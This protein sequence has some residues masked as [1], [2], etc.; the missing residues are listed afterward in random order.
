MGVP[1][2]FT[3]KSF[4]IFKLHCLSSW[5][6]KKAIILIGRSGFFSEM[7]GIARSFFQYLSPLF[8][9]F[10][11]NKLDILLEMF[12]NNKIIDSALKISSSVML[13]EGQK[14]ILK[15]IYQNQIPDSG[16]NMPKTGFGWK[17]K[18]YEDIFSHEDNV[19]L[20]KKTGI[21]GLSL[22]QNRKRHHKRGFYGLFSLKSWLEKIS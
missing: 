2:F 6:F 14:T 7:F 17:T 22:L 20:I 12:L 11:K 21:D 8:L 5:F 1:L 15:K 13:K 19:F 18:N 10:E 3:A 9:S 4:S 16:W